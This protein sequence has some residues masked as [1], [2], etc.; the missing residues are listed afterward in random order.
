[1]NS[2]GI[3]NIMAIQMISTPFVEQNLQRVSE[4]IEQNYVDSIDLI[5]LP[6]FFIQ[7]THAD[8][9][10]RFDCAETI[11]N[12]P[13]QQFMSALALQYRCY[14]VAGTILI[15]DVYNNKYFNASIVFNSFGEL[16]AVYNKIHLFRYSNGIQ[17]YDETQTFSP[18]NQIVTFSINGFKLGLGICYDLRFPEFFRKMGKVDVIILP[19]AFTY[20]TGLAHWEL[21]CKCRAVENQC[22]FVGVDQ[23]GMHLTGRR[24]YGHSLII[25]P[26]GD[27]I[28]KCSEGEQILHARLETE[29]IIEVRGK[30]PALEHRIFE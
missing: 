16:I 6:E 4:L 5:V 20:E 18:G 11:G 25:D 14:I 23:G 2:G 30:L 1:M 21:L 8:D 9:S 7:I 26:W 10:K 29:K 12:G 17:H 13:I 15:K 22:Y 19:A 28:S 3:L 24:T 27:T